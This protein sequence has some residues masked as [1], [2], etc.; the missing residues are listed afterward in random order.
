[1]SISELE[2]EFESDIG[3]PNFKIRPGIRFWHCRWDTGDPSAAIKEKEK[4]VC[5]GREIPGGGVIDKYLD[6]S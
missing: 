5:L 1:M 6:G 2:S 4:P 3:F